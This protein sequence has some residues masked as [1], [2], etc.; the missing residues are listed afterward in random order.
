[1]TDPELATRQRHAR[2]AYLGTMGRI[3]GA[4]E[5]MRAIATDPKIADD[6]LLV[7]LALSAQNRISQVRKTMGDN[8]SEDWRKV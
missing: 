2:W 6:A 8:H 1:M 5:L 7:A 4:E 3:R